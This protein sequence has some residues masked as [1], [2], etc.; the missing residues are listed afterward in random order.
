MALQGNLRDFSATEI[1]QLVASQRKTG[2]LMLEWNT[3]RAVVYVQ[4]GRIVSTR[5]PGMVKDDPL[6]GFLLKVHRLS[7]EQYRGLLT[8]QRESNRDLEDL[9]LNGRYLEADELAGFVERQ[10]LDDLMRLTRWESGGYRFD[11]NSRW[12]NTP[13]VRLN[14]E[15]VLIEAARRVDE[16]RRF[17]TIFRDPYQL[18]GVKDL[19]D[20]NEPLSEEERELFGVINGKHTVA[21]IVEAASLSEYEAYES[22]H[23]MLE[24]SWIEVVG[25]RDPGLPDTGERPPVPVVRR[26]SPLRELA[27]ATTVAACMVAL[28]FISS[29]VPRAA[30]RSAAEDVFAVTQVRDLRLALDLFH[31]E[32]GSYPQRLEELVEDRW[33]APR[34][35]NI[36]GYLVRYRLDPDGDAYTLE[37]TPDR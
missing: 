6:L 5:R 21:E 22:L 18:L 25:R 27:M 20:P 13:L 37:L 28:H 15:G 11:P 12:S 2:C 23:R 7:D 10:I 17:V 16:Q 33:I 14:I 36:G 26:K 30:V 29:A 8:I 31:R 32:R 9:L 1:L 24:A 34:Q 35:R 19:P 4:E 3:E